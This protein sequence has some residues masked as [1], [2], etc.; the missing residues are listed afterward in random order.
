[1]GDAA[2]GRVD[3]GIFGVICLLRL[4]DAKSYNA[5]SLKT[6]VLTEPV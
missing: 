3:E 4:G 5:G 2:K 6:C 1:M